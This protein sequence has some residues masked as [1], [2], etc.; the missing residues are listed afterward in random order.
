MHLGPLDNQKVPVDNGMP[1]CPHNPSPPKKN[2]LKK[3]KKAE[4]SFFSIF[5]KLPEN[6]NRKVFFSIGVFFLLNPPP[7]AIKKN[8][9]KQ[10]IHK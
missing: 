2:C 7:L 6:E 10:F 8:A 5:G 3:A 9:E 1:S 4:K